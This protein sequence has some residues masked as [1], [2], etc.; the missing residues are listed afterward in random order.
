M[1]LNLGGTWVLDAI[2][3][4]LPR[5]AMDLNRIRYGS[6]PSGRCWLPRGAMDL[7]GST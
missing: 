2:D 7:N 1:D 5:G 3:S 6:R 4:W